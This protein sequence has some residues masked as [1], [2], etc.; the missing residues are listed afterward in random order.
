MASEPKGIPLSPLPQC[1]GYKCPSPCLAFQMWI[2]GIILMSQGSQGKQI[3]D[4]AIPA[5]HVSM[6]ILL[7]VVSLS[8][9]G[10]SPFRVESLAIK[11]KSA[12]RFW[13]A[14]QESKPLEDTWGQPSRIHLLASDSFLVVPLALFQ[15]ETHTC[16]PP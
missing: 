12:F 14:P 10:Q 3:T 16:C 6:G 7:R 11:L 15:L 9:E 2:L 5:A 8:G 13:C 4:W 1:W